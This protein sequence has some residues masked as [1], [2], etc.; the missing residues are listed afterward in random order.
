MG[1]DRTNSHSRPSKGGGENPEGS[2]LFLGGLSTLIV[3]VRDVNSSSE[4]VLL[5]LSSHSRESSRR[6]S[7]AFVV[8][9]DTWLEGPMRRKGREG[10][11]GGGEGSE[12]RRGR[13][14][15]EVDQRRARS[16]PF[17]STNIRDETHWQAC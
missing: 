17:L 8:G 4:D 10:S 3:C 9:V 14:R 5:L 11:E 16:S 13:G 15:G 12:K 1:R 2:N 6:E 7:G